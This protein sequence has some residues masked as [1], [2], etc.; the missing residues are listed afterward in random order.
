MPKEIR[1]MLLCE[2][3]MIA[4]DNNQ[5]LAN[6]PSDHWV[7]FDYS[8][9]GEVYE[10]TCEGCGREYDGNIYYFATEYANA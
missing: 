4:H 5:K 3:C 9:I 8:Q 1:D 7:E 6:V 2:D 10:H